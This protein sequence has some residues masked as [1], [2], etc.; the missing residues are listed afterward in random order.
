MI[1]SSSALMRRQDLWIHIFMDQTRVRKVADRLK[2][3]P[4][5]QKPDEVQHWE[6]ET[7]LNSMSRDTMFCISNQLH[8]LILNKTNYILNNTRSG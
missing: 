7:S 5:I 2:S 4:S 8:I 1:F 3:R 6:T